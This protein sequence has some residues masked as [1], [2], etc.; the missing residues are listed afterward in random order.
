MISLSTDLWAEQVPESPILIPVIGRR[1]ELLDPLRPEES[2]AG[3]LA[4]DYGV[5]GKRVRLLVQGSAFRKRFRRSEQTRPA[6]YS[7]LRDRITNMKVGEFVFKK[8]R[9]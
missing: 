3:L 9:T 5:A 7:K 8:G 1:V 2:I 6:H 4:N